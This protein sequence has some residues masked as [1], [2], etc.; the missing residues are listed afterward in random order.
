MLKHAE[1]AIR[2]T[3]RRPG[4]ALHR[5]SP[6]REDIL[7]PYYR[8]GS[9]WRTD[10]VR[11]GI[12][13]ELLVV[14]GRVMDTAGRPLVGALIDVWQ[15]DAAGHYDNEPGHE[16]DEYLLRGQMRSDGTGRYAFRTV[17]PGQYEMEDGVKRPRHIHYNV[18]HPGMRPL[19]TQ[20]YFEGDPYLEQ[21]PYGHPELVIPLGPL[22][23]QSAGFAGVFDVVLERMSLA[24]H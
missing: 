10:L 9:P 18:S 11:P 12:E 7:G 23:G 22:P 15:A 19:T 13:G 6:T 20:L 3:P 17:L 4:P 21:D 5:L 16:S 8:P 14:Q 2:I 24:T 1:H